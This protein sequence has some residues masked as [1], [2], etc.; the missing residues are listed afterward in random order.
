MTQGK[1]HA[2]LGGWA[3]ENNM[4]F[5]QFDHFLSKLNLCTSISAKVMLWHAFLV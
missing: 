1:E 4:N 2:H 3:D 5:W